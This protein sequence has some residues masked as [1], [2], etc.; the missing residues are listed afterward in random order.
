MAKIIPDR[1]NRVLQGAP[2]E[3]P[4]MDITYDEIDSLG[5]KEDVIAMFK[6]IARYNAMLKERITFINA[7]ITAAVPFTKENLYLICGYSGNGK[8]FA[9]DTPI[10]MYDGSI[11]KVQDVEVGDQVMGP[12]SMPR[13]VLNLS[14]GIDRMYEVTP[15]KGDS[16]TVNSNHV[17]SL[18]CST[19]RKIYKNYSRGDICNIPVTKWID[20]SQSFKVAFKGYRSGVEFDEQ[21]VELDPYY[22]GIWLGDGTSENTAVTSMEPEIVSFIEKFA[23]KNSLHLK[24][25][26]HGSRA[27]EY[28]FSAGRSGGLLRNPILNSLK[29]YNVLNNK[30]IPK[31]YLQNSAEV[32]MQVLAGLIDTDGGSG[33][34]GFYDITFKNKN[35]AYDTVYLARSLGFAAYVKKVYKK[36]CNSKTQKVGEYYRISIAGHCSKIPVKVPRK[37]IAARRQIKDVLNVGIEVKPVGIGQYFGFEVDGDH[38]F[39]LGDFTV[40]HNSTIAANVSYPLWQEGK[41]SLVITNEESK[42]DVYM[43]I[44]CLQLG[45]NFNEYKKGLMPAT[46]QV[47]CAKLIPQIAQF[48]KVADVN[49]KHKSIDNAT[50]TVE[51]VKALLSSVMNSDYS[52]V[53]LDYYQLI[54]K[55]IERPDASSYEVLN[56]FRIWLGQFIKRAEI[57]VVI[58]AQLHSLGKRNNKDLDSRIKHCAD[59]YETS[60]VVIEVIPN[61][62]ERTSDFLI[63]KDRF[64]LAGNRIPCAFEKGRYVNISEEAMQKLRNEKVT[65]LKNLIDGEPSKEEVVDEQ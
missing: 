15:T 55:S 45:C 58:F 29:K 3:A 53:M 18:R 30:H 8:C 63:V 20:S 37:K 49:F 43:R 48:V 17:L 6:N 36:C 19:S 13:T 50:A 22:L 41:K 31:Q 25:Y 59:I 44:A 40:T 47:E 51:G 11:K 4:K 12:D 33:E 26:N 5:S 65:D 9:P 16:Y 23:K 14:S 64:G 2:R 28:R 42:E 7:T 1:I 56:D 32:R 10:L 61:F 57:P 35:L 34:N 62:E 54:K 52:C 38:L 24:T 21:P 46:K 60:T 39:L 27:L